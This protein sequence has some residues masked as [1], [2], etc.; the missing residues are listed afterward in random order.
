[1]KSLKAFLVG[2]LW[3]VIMMVMEITINTIAEEV[4]RIDTATIISLILIAPFCEELFRIK[5]GL[6][7]TGLIILL[8]GVG[9]SVAIAEYS[10]SSNSSIVLVII[11]M[12]LLWGSRLI[13]MIFY[14]I[15]LL[16]GVVKAMIIHGSYNA[17]LL[18]GM[19]HVPYLIDVTV[20]GGITTL[21]VVMY[22]F[23]IKREYITTNQ[24]IVC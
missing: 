13:H 1:M 24:E 16:H 23:F 17:V 7:Y 3:F 6:T 5:G 2:M 22:F 18:I 21:C 19:G 8:E 4:V 9:Y 20:W 10:M 15:N 12:L 11:T 14:H